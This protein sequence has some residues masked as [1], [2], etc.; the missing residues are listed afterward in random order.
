MA[1]CD[2][3]I[4]TYSH[5]IDHSAED[6][7]SLLAEQGFRLF[8]LL[9]YPGHAWA[10]EMD[11]GARARF[12]RFLSERSL[13]VRTVNQPNLDLNIAAA[14][15]EMR[16]YSLASLTR[17]IEFAGELEAPFVLIGPGK[18]NGLVPMPR[19]QAT[20]H[21]HRALDR[22]LPIASRAGTR[23]VVE[24]MPFGLFCDANGLLQAVESHG[25]PDVGIVYD[26]ANGFFIGEDL[27]GA[28]LRCGERLALVHLS[29]TGRLSY[30]HDPVGLGEIDFAAVLS[31]LAAIGWSDPLVLEIVG[32]GEGLA[33]R[34]A[35]SA[36]RLDA[37]RPIRTDM[38]ELRPS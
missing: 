29:D 3:V 34:F 26:V 6:A 5:S 4:T 9:M 25:S 27:K 17:T 36:C 13:E 1:V 21:F 10:A 24:N 7:M 30:R 20:G 32:S 18:L 35:E 2:Y 15:S 28:L 33:A 38:N 31:E 8:E 23:L 16:E 37:L 12:K 19:E 14:T 11:A 22:L